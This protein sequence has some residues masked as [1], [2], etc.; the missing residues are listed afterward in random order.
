MTAKQGKLLVL[1]T[2]GVMTALLLRAAASNGEW[3]GFAVTELQLAVPMAIAWRL[4]ATK[5]LTRER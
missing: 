4:F 3:V 2:V 1:V 5:G